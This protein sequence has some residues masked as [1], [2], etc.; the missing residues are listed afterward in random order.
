[1][2][3][4]IH[5]TVIVPVDVYLKLGLVLLRDGYSLSVFEDNST[6]I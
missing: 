2:K 5:K 3:A 4:V 6:Y 1:V